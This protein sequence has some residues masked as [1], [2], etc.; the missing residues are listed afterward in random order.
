MLEVMLAEWIASLI[1]VLCAITFS[2]IAGE[3]GARV[4][5]LCIGVIA[6]IGGRLFWIRR[7]DRGLKALIKGSA[8][9]LL[10]IVALLICLGHL[11]HSKAVSLASWYA[12]QR[13]GPSV[14]LLVMQWVLVPVPFG[15]PFW[16][17]SAM[18]NA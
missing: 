9:Y 6:S 5:F 1:G 10:S 3:A 18:R 8:P 12:Q 17:V 15:L 7:P 11:E 16:R 4:T 2:A 13:I 14:G